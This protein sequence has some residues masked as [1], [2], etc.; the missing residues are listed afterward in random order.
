VQHFDAWLCKEDREAEKIDVD[1]P[2]IKLETRDTTIL[3]ENNPYM[4]IGYRYLLTPVSR[5]MALRLVDEE[6]HQL[7]RTSFHWEA[8]DMRYVEGKKA[9]IARLRGLFSQ[10]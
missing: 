5:A 9:D 2:H 1:Y 10:V 4:M 7:Y 3:G 6:E 8:C